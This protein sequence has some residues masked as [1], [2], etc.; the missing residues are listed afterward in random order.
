MN[1]DLSKLI[2][3]LEEAK[4]LV[5]TDDSWYEL[6]YNSGIDYAIDIIKAHIKGEHE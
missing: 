6:G 3:D 5:W 4:Q 2:E 1:I